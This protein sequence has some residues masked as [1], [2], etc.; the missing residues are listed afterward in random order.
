MQIVLEAKLPP[1]ERDEMH[2]ISCHR[3]WQSVSFSDAIDH[4]TV[5]F[6]SVV[7]ATRQWV[8]G[9]TATYRV[10]PDAHP[11]WADMSLD[12]PP[13]RGGGSAR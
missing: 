10:H 4:T 13:L 2:C 6:A 12:P 9:N 5:C 11:S 7:V 8:G 3:Q 1:V